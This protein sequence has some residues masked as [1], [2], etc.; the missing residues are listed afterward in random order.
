MFSD[1]Q[2]NTESTY[3]HKQDVNQN[4][5]KEETMPVEYNNTKYLV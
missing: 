5:C 3:K 4:W 1:A 2:H